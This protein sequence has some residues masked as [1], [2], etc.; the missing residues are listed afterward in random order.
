MRSRFAV[1]RSDADIATERGKALTRQQ[2]FHPPLHSHEFR[3]APGLRSAIVGEVSSVNDDTSDNLFL[4]APARFPAIV[5]DAPP[6]HL[7]C[8]ES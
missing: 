7:L 3:A 2:D 6:T 5:E 1:K 4:D 8:N